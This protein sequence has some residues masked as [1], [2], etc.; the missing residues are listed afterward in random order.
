MR[1]LTFNDITNT[2]LAITICL[3]F[4]FLGGNTYTNI[5]TSNWRRLLLEKG[6]GEYNKKTGNWQLCEPEVVLLNHNTEAI[7]IL[8]GGTVT[9]SDY[10]KIV[11]T[12]Y[13][14]AQKRIEEQSKE[15]IEQD[16]LLE[17]YKKSIKIPG[18]SGKKTGKSDGRPLN[19]I[20]LS[21]VV[22]MKVA[23]ANVAN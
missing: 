18:E 7:K 15:L 6:Y 4:F 16:L 13:R 12:D 22:P 1:K 19:S 11:E 17:K 8:N 9:I 3:T 23:R 2:I 5:H 21:V 14:E 20:D 10:L